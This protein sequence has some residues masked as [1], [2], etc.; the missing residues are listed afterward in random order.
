LTGTSPSGR[1]DSEYA[2]ATRSAA[3]GSGVDRRRVRY[4]ANRSTRSDPRDP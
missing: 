4:M 2:F 1:I 3:L